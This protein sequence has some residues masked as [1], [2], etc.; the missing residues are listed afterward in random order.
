MKQR[1]AHFQTSLYYVLWSAMHSIMFHCLIVSL[2]HWHNNHIMIYFGLRNGQVLTA[3]VELK[4]SLNPK[5]AILQASFWN[6]FLENNFRV[7]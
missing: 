2:F 6:A 1:V 4:Y 7:F 5:T 3:P